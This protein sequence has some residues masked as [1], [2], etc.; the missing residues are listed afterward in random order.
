MMVGEPP[1]LGQYREFSIHDVRRRAAKERPFLP[2]PAGSPRRSDVWK[3]A[4]G[5]KRP[6]PPPPGSSGRSDVFVAPRRPKYPPGG[7]SPPVAVVFLCG[8]SGFQTSAPARQ[9]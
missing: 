2:P 4:R 8:P 5:K 3:P 1:V 7:T 6:S 9:A